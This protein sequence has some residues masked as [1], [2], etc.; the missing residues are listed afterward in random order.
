MSDIIVIKN[1]INGQFVGSKEYLDSFDPATGRLN[2]RVPDS[3]TSDVAQA[4]KAAKNAFKRY[5]Q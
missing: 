4:V 1:F 5:V 3:D 2:A